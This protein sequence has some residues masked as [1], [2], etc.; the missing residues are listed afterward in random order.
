MSSGTQARS[1]RSVLSTVIF[2]PL[3]LLERSRGVWRW[4]LV[5]VYGV[6]AAVG[7]GYAARTWNLS[8]IPDMAPSF[9]LAAY[10]D[11]GPDDAFPLYRQANERYEAPAGQARYEVPSLVERIL[12]MHHNAGSVT[13]AVRAWIDKN[14]PALDLWR[15]ATER[16]GLGYHPRSE[17]GIGSEWVESGISNQVAIGLAT[18]VRVFDPDRGLLP[19]LAEYEAARLREAGDA[20]GAWTW[21]RALLRYSRHVGMR[22]GVSNRRAA[23][24]RHAAASDRAEAWVLDSNVD[25]ALL[26]QALTDVLEVGKLTPPLS[27]TLKADY[28]ETLHLIDAP[29]MAVI[30]RVVTDYGCNG[31]WQ[32][33]DR[34]PLREDIR[35]A[36][37]EWTGTETNPYRSYLPD[38]RARMVFYVQHEPETSRRLVGQVYANWLAHC[39]EPSKQRPS[40]VSPFELFDAPPSR[41]GMLAIPDVIEA[42]NGPRVARHVISPWSELEKMLEDEQ[43][44]QAQLVV[45]IAEQLYQ[46]ERG[47]APTTIRDLVGSYLK[48]IPQGYVD[49][50]EEASPSP[51]VRFGR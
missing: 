33:G 3:I 32:E 44:R 46:R 17:R 24:E 38:V 18:P 35:F 31:D 37:G 4:W 50:L 41:P 47:V 7:I 10:R 49:P 9:N 45:A 39:D 40:T 22:S 48:E 21:L 23:V 6:L 15:Q 8:R 43:R 28:L 19:W 14:R 30:N 20:A 36:P 1:F 16:S 2:A 29:T 27:D 25:P 34:P 5:I 12:V 11:G 51:D 26:R 42:L 13:P